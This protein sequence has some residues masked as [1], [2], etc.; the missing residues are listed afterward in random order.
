MTLRW[1]SSVRSIDYFHSH[2]MQHEMENTK[3]G[4][5][6]HAFTTLGLVCTI[7]SLSSTG[8]S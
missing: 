3:Y 1:S 4:K 2:K 8:K 6:L 5:L 7:E